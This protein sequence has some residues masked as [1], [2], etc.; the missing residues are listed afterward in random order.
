MTARIIAGSG[1][2]LEEVVTGIVQTQFSALKDELSDEL[3]QTISDSLSNVAGAF[4]CGAVK[5]LKAFFI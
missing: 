3:K 5:L 4:G 2:S 1:P